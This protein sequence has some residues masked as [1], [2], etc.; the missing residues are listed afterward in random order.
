MIFFPDNALNWATNS[1]GIYATNTDLRGQDL[2]NSIQ[3]T[4]KDCLALCAATSTCTHISYGCC[5]TSWWTP[6]T[7]WLKKE[8]RSQLTASTLSDVQSAILNQSNV[9][10]YFNILL[11]K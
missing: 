7:C 5:Q 9:F 3:G 1:Y 6:G 10:N 2:S 4:F 11:F 8:P